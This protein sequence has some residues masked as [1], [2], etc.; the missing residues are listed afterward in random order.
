MTRLPLSAIRCPLSFVPLCLLLS[1]CFFGNRPEARLT[2]E[3]SIE[4]AF[5]VLGATPDGKTLINFLNEKP[6]RFEYGNTPGLC[7]KF[8]LKTRKI[9]LPR[10]LRDS[11]KLL[12]MAAARAAYIYRLYVT[13]GLDEI[14]S[15]EEELGALFQ[16][17]IGLEIKLMDTDFKRNKAA[18]ELKS[19]FCTYL[20]EGSKSAALAAR[21]TALSSMP[22]CQRPLETL[23][24]QRVWLNE[25]RKAINAG[26]FYQLLYDRDLHKVHKGVMTQG[27]A[28][29]NDA[30]IRSLPTYEIYRYQRVFYDQQSDIFS[31]IE[32][33]YNSALRDDEAWRTANQAA[34][35]RA[36]EE[37]STCN[38]PD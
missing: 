26:S 17:R 34:I 22:E 21:T 29:K 31:S 8:F 20:M 37:F 2:S 25:T 11:D 27:E 4:R 14:I 10:E 28:M 6:V 13:S 3:P 23:Q 1:G 36:R 18:K 5:D 19:D 30:A 32:S 7:N 33:L 15:E 9:F 16:A 38:L 24:A 35:D 12:A